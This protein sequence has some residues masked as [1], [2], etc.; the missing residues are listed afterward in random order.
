MSSFSVVDSLYY[1]RGFPA[2]TLADALFTTLIAQC[3]G[4]ECG[5]LIGLYLAAGDPYSAMMAF[6]AEHSLFT[7]EEK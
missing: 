5:E 2:L 3:Q 1:T 7:G 4:D 6:A